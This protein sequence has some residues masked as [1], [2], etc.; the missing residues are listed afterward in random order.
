MRKCA[1]LRCCYWFRVCF[2]YEKE[3]CIQSKHDCCAVKERKKVFLPP[4]FSPSH[5]YYLHLSAL[6]CWPL[7]LSQL[8]LH[9]HSAA[10]LYFFLH[11]ITHH[12]FE[13]ADQNNGRVGMPQIISLTPISPP[14]QPLS[15][16]SSIWFRQKN[17]P[18]RVRDMMANVAIATNSRVMM[19]ISRCWRRAEREKERKKGH[20]IG[21]T[22]C[23]IYFQDKFVISSVSMFSYTS[24]CCP[25]PFSPSPALRAFLSPRLDATLSLIR[26]CWHHPCCC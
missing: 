18:Q 26:N 9:L 15:S 4:I 23:P 13:L 16:S 11:C 14:P 21:P 5:L 2:S 20:A 10:M 25:I 17:A 3:I 8:R 24:A 6:P 19:T 7:L 12:T 1:Y 22:N